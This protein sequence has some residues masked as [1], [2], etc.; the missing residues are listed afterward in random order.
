MQPKQQAR[1]IR[2]L[3]LPL[4]RRKSRPRRP[5]PSRFRSP[6]QSPSRLQSQRWP[7]RQQS[8]RDPRLQQL[9]DAPRHH[10]RRPG[11]P[12]PRRISGT[13]SPLVKPAETGQRTLATDT[14]AG[15]SSPTAR[16][17]R[18]GVPLAARNSPLTRGKRHESSRSPSP[19][20]S[21]PDPVGARGPGARPSRRD[22]AFLV[23]FHYGDS[24][25]HYAPSA[26]ERTRGLFAVIS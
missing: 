22:E 15:F 7:L 5:C 21:S 26:Y 16:R 9:S 11:T 13:D 18:H 3:L 25:H 2:A 17:G 12:Q 14:E 23:W 6:S 24:R 4:S 19:S 20:A 8:L 10:R 1:P